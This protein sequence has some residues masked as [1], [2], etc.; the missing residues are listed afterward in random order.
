MDDMHVF[1]CIMQAL[2]KLK[3]LDVE[4]FYKP[5]IPT[6]E[7]MIDAEFINS[8]V[9]LE[10]VVDEELNPDFCIRFEFQNRKKLVIFDL[11]RGDYGGVDDFLKYRYLTRFAELGQDTHNRDPKLVDSVWLLGK[12]KGTEDTIL[13]YQDENWLGPRSIPVGGI[14]KISTDE[15]QGVEDMIQLLRTVGIRR[16]LPDL[17][18]NGIRKYEY[19]KGSWHMSGVMGFDTS[20]V[21]TANSA[22]C[23]RGLI[24]LHNGNSRDPDYRPASLWS[25]QITTHPTNPKY[26]LYYS[27]CDE[28]RLKIMTCLLEHNK[29]SFDDVFN[30]SEKV[31]KLYYEYDFSEYE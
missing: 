9:A 17:S 21:Q 18:P 28:M 19:G 11:F 1:Y 12:K 26:V 13:P 16:R 25:G 22:L 23:S 3:R 29:K 8:S 6:M 24:Y 14:A 30:D 27:D 10:K 7:K 5:A 31:R 4:L 2:I 20:L 15:G